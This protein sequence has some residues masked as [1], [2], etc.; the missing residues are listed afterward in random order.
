M[1]QSK[2][3]F[4]RFNGFAERSGDQEASVD[5]L[6]RQSNLYCHPITST[7]LCVSSVFRGAEAT[8]EW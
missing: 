7:S 4:P 8:Y 6:I 1:L 5:K 3:F 2:L